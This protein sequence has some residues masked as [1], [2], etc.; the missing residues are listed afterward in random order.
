M[1]LLLWRLP[2]YV[3]QHIHLNW[4]VRHLGWTRSKVYLIEAGVRLLAREHA[5]G[6]SFYFKYRKLG[7]MYL[8]KKCSFF[9]G[10]QK[11]DKK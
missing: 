7:F 1:A 5:N 9:V 4:S 8:P 11:K 3:R 6:K 10:S 2:T